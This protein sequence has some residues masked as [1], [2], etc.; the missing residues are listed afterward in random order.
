VGVAHRHL[1]GRV[2]HELLHRLERHA[3]HGEV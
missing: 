2:A 1:D 3:P